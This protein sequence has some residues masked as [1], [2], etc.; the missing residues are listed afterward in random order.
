MIQQ[1]APFKLYLLQESDQLL[2]KPK[3]AYEQGIN[4][5]I[6]NNGI[7]R[8]Q[9]LHEI[10]TRGGIAQ[11]MFFK[12]TLLF[13]VLPFQ[14]ILVRKVKVSLRKAEYDTAFEIF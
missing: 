4:Q 7:K 3:G 14:I 1:R 9:T 5:R 2:G 13:L 8:R 11:T 10:F 12:F 6:T